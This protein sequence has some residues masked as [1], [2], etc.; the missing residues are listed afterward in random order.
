M[1]VNQNSKA[2][3]N[4]IS[5][6]KLYRHVLQLCKITFPVKRVHIEYYKTWFIFSNVARVYGEQIPKYYY[7]YYYSR[8]HNKNKSMVYWIIGTSLYLDIGQEYSRFIPSRSPNV[9]PAQSAMALYNKPSVAYFCDYI[10]NLR[11]FVN[12]RVIKILPLRYDDAKHLYR[13]YLFVIFIKRWRKH[14]ILPKR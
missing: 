9:F 2:S 13:K 4:N 1:T 11:T 14:Q 3:N 6:F 12:N 10:F 7:Y 5:C 8:I